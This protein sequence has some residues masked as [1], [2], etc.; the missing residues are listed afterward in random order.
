MG[1]VSSHL[2][3][4]E[5]VMHKARVHWID[6]ISVIMYDIYYLIW[7]GAASYQVN[8]TGKG[9]G[10][11]IFMI[12]LLIIGNIWV[13]FSRY[14]FLE[15][16]VTNKRIVFKRGFLAVKTEEQMIKDLEGVEIE[17]TAWGRILN[18]A[19]L[20]FISTGHSAIEFPLVANPI[21]IK[22]ITEKCKGI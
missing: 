16:V 10:V 13:Y 1:Y 19:N 12:I 9:E 4:G 18:Y 22:Q 15:M 5:Q 7:C 21:K 20:Y 6:F 11:V 3:N 8:Q 17:Q 14:H 2:S